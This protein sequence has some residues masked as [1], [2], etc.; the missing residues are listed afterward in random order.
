M[1]L[2][3][4]QNIVKDFDGK[5]LFKPLTFEVKSG[6]RTAL[7]GLNGTGKSTIMKMASGELEPDQGRMIVGKG[8]S[9]GYLSQAVISNEEHT[10][11]EEASSVFS[12]NRDLIDQIAA[13]CQR[14]ALHPEERNLQNDYAIKQAE[15]EKLGGYDYEYRIR[16]ILNMFGFKKEDWDRRISTFSGGEKTRM[17]F[18]KLLLINPDLLLLDEPTNHLDIVTIQWLEDYLKS[19]R[20]A[21]LFVSHDKT[22]IN[23]LADRIIELENGT[24]SFY[25]GNYD[26]Y[27]LEKQHRYELALK[28]YNRQQEEME[29]IQRFITFYMP[30]PRF[31]SRAHDREKKLARL[32]ATAL[33]KPQLQKNKVHIDFKGDIREDKK[34][35]RLTDVSIGYPDSEK[36]LIEHIDYEIRGRDHI[37]VMG[38]N[39]AG[40]TTFVK[41]LL[42]QI[43]PL[44]GRIDQL[45]MLNIGYLRQDF[46][47]IQDP[48][49]I[50]D[51]FKDNFPLLEDQRIYDHLG[52]FAFS[53]Q[54]DREKTLKNLSGGEQMRV[55]LAKLCLENYDILILD[56]P[57]NHLDLFTKSE[58]EDALSEYQ[59]TLIL[60]SHDRDFIDRCADRIIYFHDSRAY[61]YEG[62]YTDFMEGDLKKIVEEEKAKVT[63]GEEHTEESKPQVVKPK[64]VSEYTVEKLME[65][66]AK[67]EEDISR[68]KALCDTPEYY[69]DSKKLESLQKDID[70]K[71]SEVDELYLKLNSMG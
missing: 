63:Q 71:Q 59:G 39:G 25:R 4:A 13:I 29:R 11:F 64:R 37:A 65:K 60:I 3:Q 52:K 45:T 40:K 17:A 34:L 8:V 70:S 48:R 53:Y 15:L 28:E 10:L 26:A 42:G 24:L 21:V 30:K 32:K 50:F 31:V 22:F 41:T 61:T 5:P 57:T 23:N 54:D 6:D 16:M 2:L 55:I 27:A 7:I 38:A 14:M 66:I 44:S 35:I 56:E 36:P 47:N 20:G 18:A 68:L 19:Y 67:K 33:D 62:S 51:Y 1:I 58:L 12:R 9:V 49:T 43:K 46:L 69:S